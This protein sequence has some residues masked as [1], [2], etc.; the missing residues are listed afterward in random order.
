MPGGRSEKEINTRHG[1]GLWPKT[2]KD[3]KQVPGSQE[4]LGSP[5]A[6]A[7][8]RNERP[9]ATPFRVRAYAEALAAYARTRNWMAKG[10]PVSSTGV[11]SSTLGKYV[12]R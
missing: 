6:Y 7:R 5:E 8:T 1:V 2:P 9:K 3:H 4:D 11:R 10:Q 12:F